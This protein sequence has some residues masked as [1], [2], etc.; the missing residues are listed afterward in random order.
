MNALLPGKDNSAFVPHRRHLRSG[1][2]KVSQHRRGC[3]ADSVSPSFEIR[4]RLIIF[5]SYFQPITVQSEDIAA[6]ERRVLDARKRLQEVIKH[7]G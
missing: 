4:K 6:Q 1:L 3:I 2:L 5:F 7:F